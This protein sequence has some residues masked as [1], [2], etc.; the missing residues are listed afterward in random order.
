M[1]GSYEV[2]EK[3]CAA[4][5]IARHHD[6]NGM[7]TPISVSP[8]GEFSVEFVEC[9]AS[10]GTAPVCMVQDELIENVRPEAAPPFSPITNH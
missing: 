7:H 8:D 1:A 10:C 5:G 3:A 4:A 6:D 9:L 2:M